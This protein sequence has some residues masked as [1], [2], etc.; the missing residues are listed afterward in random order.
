MSK[1]EYIPLSSAAIQPNRKL[2]ISKCSKGG[3]TLAQQLDVQEQNGHS[4]SVFLKN[5]VHVDDVNGLY[6]LRDA[7][8]IAIDKVEKEK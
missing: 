2:V 8:N 6:E 5:A 3:F 4:L 7:V 1:V